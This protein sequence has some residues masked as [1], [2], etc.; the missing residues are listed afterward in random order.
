MTW[1]LVTSGNASIFSLVKVTTP[2]T[3]S[4]QRRRERDRAPVDGEVDEL[5]EHGG[6]ERARSAH[7]HHLHPPCPRGTS[8]NYVLTRACGAQTE[9][10][11]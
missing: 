6:A 2:K 9:R 5:V 11:L 1:T 8:E 10:N 3:A 7:P 4:T